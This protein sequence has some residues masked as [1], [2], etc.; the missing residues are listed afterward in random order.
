MR[1]EGV[2]AIIFG[3]LI[4]LLFA[5]G[6]FRINGVMKQKSLTATLN[7]NG[8]STNT[9][10]D[11]DYPNPSLTLLKPKN[12]QVF[13]VDII[14]ISGATKPES[15]IIATGG[16]E[17][18]FTETG[19][20]G[21]FNFDYEIAP[22][23]NQLNISS[24]STDNSRSS[25]KYEVVYSSEVVKKASPDS[26]N[27]EDKIKEKLDSVQK[28]TEFYKGT[29]TDITDNNM[30]MKTSNDEIKQISYEA[31]T[32]T[33]AKVG[34][35]M[36]KIT[37]SD[38][39]IGD[40]ILALGQKSDNGVLE[41]FRIIVTQPSIPEEI[42]VF[43]GTVSQ[44]SKTDME[45]SEQGALNVLVEIDNNSKTYKGEL[46]DPIRAR[47]AD[48]KEGDTVIGTY[49]TQKELNIARKINVL[50]SDK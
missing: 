49:S 21:S 9:V 14:Q 13:G 10:T 24:I 6:I 38:I 35:T 34:K 45:I 28:I 16:T 26:E 31:N 3:V 36:T 11:I 15:Y 29:I 46:F 5:F 41:T 22:L 1:K 39:A 23:L 19:N 40:Y 37:A 47:F 8:N 48:I 43:Y 20:D 33:F 42:K 30:Q 27:M 25:I 4:G 32:T 50:I 17:D 2:Y 44:K 7:N 12:M 18:Y